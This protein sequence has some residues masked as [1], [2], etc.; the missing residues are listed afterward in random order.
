MWK[1]TLFLHHVVPLLDLDNYVSLESHYIDLNKLAEN[2]M[3]N[4]QL[5]C[6]H[7]GFAKL[8]LTILYLLAG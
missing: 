3:V 8:V 6:F 2:G 7:R 1:R 4:W 5:R